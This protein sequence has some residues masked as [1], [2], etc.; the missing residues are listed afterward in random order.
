MVGKKVKKSHQPVIVVGD[1]NDVA[2][3]Y[4]TDL[5]L[6][7]SELLD[8]RKG[9]GFFNS[10]HAKYFFLRFPLDHVFCTEHF[11]LVKMKR[12]RSCG[13][14][15]FPMFVSLQYDPVAD[16]E[17]EPESADVEEQQTAER[18]IQEDTR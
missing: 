18:K 10:F 6:K 12:L 17:N 13:S 15:H 1:L 5:F 7:T 2:W 4:T 16:A 8:P 11:S 9:R 14:D 3:S